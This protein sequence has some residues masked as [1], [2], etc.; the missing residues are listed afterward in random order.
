MTR[1]DGRVALVT[2]AARGIGFATAR[3]LTSEGAKVGLVDV[4]Q[5]ALDEAVKKLSNEGGVVYSAKADVGDVTEVDA[6]VT[7]IANAL[8]PIDILVNNAGMAVVKKYVDHTDE[9]IQRQI[10]TNLMAPHFFMSRVLPGMMDR[11]RG[12]IVNISS[13]AALYYTFPHAGY[14][15]SKAALVAFTRDVAFEAARQGI[16]VNCVAPGLIAVEY[17]M[18]NLEFDSLDQGT[19][20]RPMGWGRPQDVAEVVCFLA[21]DQARF[22][23]G[24]TIPVAGGTNLLVSMTAN[25][26]TERLE[27]PT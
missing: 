11:G 14:A 25:E 1:F 2:G 4:D 3:Q 24:V 10:Q 13:V 5:A 9:D 19:V 22:V 27:Q 17:T 12:A 23:I 6:A 16:R 8:G 7:Q 26:A 20:F 18:N 15:A 21:S